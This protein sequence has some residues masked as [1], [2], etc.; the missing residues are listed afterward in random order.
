VM[1]TKDRQA[2]CFDLIELTD[3]VDGLPPGSHGTVTVEGIG[4]ALVD[5]SW[6]DEGPPTGCNQVQR[7]PNGSMKVVEVRS[8]DQA[9]RARR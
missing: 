6:C 7:V 3:P 8:F 5:F 2:K 1:P 9:C 4:Q